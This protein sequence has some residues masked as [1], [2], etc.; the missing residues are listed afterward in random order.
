MRR[1]AWCI[2]HRRDSKRTSAS[3]PDAAAKLKVPAAPALKARR[4]WTFIGHSMPRVE[5][6]SKIDGSANYGI[7]FQLPGMLVAAVAQSPA[8]GGR[9]QSINRATA[10]AQPGVLHVI[11]LDDTV[12]VVAA[13]YWQAS[14]GLAKAG[15]TWT[16]S[17][18][19]TNALGATL[20]SLAAAD[21]APASPAVE[22]APSAGASRTV[23]ALY[24]SP[25]LLHAQLEP[26][27]A[28]AKVDR[29]SAHLWAPTQAQSDMRDAVAKSLGQ[30]NH[31]VTVRTNLVGGG[32]G[33]RLATD[34]GVTA[35][36][37]AQRLRG[38]PV[39]VVW[40]REQDCIQAR[41]RPMS[42]ARLR[43]TL[44]ANGLIQH[45]DVHVASLGQ[46]A[47]TGGIADG[48]YTIESRE[49]RYSGIDAPVRTGSWR[50]VDSSQNLF[51]RESFIEECAHLA[52][53]D[54]L[55][56][57]RRL[58]A[59]NTRALRVL[60]VLQTLSRPTASTDPQRSLGYAFGDG[61]GSLCAQAVDVAAGA[62]GTWKIRQ[63]FAVID[64][65]TAINPAQIRAQI[66]GGILFGLSAALSEH[67]TYI[68]GT[69]QQTNYDRYRVLRMQ[70][71]P[72]IHIEIIESPDVPLGGIGEAG[73]PLI[74]PALAN[75][76]FT[77]TGTRLRSLPLRPTS[78]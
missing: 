30:F 40:S 60:D 49:V 46:G 50:S 65:G 75:A 36:R 63:V 62:D 2:T 53:I 38:T 32:F 61:L 77:A 70:D 76:V 4:E 48:P 54:P 34:D 58:L 52:G 12:A 6:A 29:F 13:T 51:Y 24:E 11:E 69:L 28:T 9:L 8:P 71:T 23:E 47:R 78:A 35:A 15:V 7:D 64:C 66:E 74:A 25:L 3:S 59:K 19:D 27:N 20:R 5:I 56:Y 73:V 18:V 44:D 67:A 10:F 31:A 14:Q 16:A 42:A 22:S 72:E 45:L 39:K 57:R 55:D 1:W 33:R 43:A 17:T 68:G 41:F 21:P 26:L 37:I